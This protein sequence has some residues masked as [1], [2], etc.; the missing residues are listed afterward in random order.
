MVIS[1]PFLGPVDPL[2]FLEAAS[3]LPAHP[4][5]TRPCA[6]RPGHPTESPVLV[7]LGCSS[8]SGTSTR[9]A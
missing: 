7:L 1:L 4:P 2:H 3:L 6:L 5:P 9:A 8:S